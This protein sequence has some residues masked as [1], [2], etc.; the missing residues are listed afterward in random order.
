MFIILN[1]YAVFAKFNNAHKSGK[2]LIRFT[3]INKQVDDSL[4]EECEA[5]FLF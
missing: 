3:F 4:N 5:L 2:M 1:I